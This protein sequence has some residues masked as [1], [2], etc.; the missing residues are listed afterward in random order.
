MLKDEKIEINIS[1]RNITHYLKLGYKPIL[2][3]N[4]LI[5][6]THLPSGS[7]IKVDV[8]CEICGAI[9]NL[10]YHKYLENKK[11]HNFYTCKKC[12][13]HKAML[14]SIDK[15]G[16]DNYSKTEEY[17]KRVEK[18]NM[19]KYGYKTNLLS[20]EYQ[21]IIKKKLKEIYNTEN[22]YEINRKGKKKK[23][24]KL[25]EDID[26][27]KKDNIFSEDLYS[28]EYLTENY[29]L[30]RNDCR[31]L[32][33]SNLKKL[34]ENWNGKDYYDDEFIYNNFSLDHNDLNYPTIDHK[35]INILGIC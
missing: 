16:V 32:T 1:Y 31:R 22:F 10:R 24:F 33:K 26:S 12:S 9:T 17:K 6:T 4:L 7:H 34:Y 23:K 30:Y 11:R 27:L 14:T 21:D 29:L 5:L 25:K 18:T 35:K 19:N 28:D 3:E 20:P 8:I 15:Y 2:N 13:R